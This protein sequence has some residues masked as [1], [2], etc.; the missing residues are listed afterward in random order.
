MPRLRFH[1]QRLADAVHAALRTRIGR[2]PATTDG[3]ERMLLAY[4][5]A[6]LADEYPNFAAAI[7]DALEPRT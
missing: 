1:D 3:R 6:N 4:L 5:A 7:R 2:A